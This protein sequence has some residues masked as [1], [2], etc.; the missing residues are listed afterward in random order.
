MNRIWSADAVGGD[1]KSGYR[2]SREQKLAKSFQLRL[3]KAS[4]LEDAVV[5]PPRSA[6]AVL[7]GQGSLTSLSSRAISPSRNVAVSPGST[8]AYAASRDEELRGSLPLMEMER[9]FLSKL[10]ELEQQMHEKLAKVIEMAG[11]IS[12]SCEE[13]FSQIE[14]KALECQAAVAKIQSETIHML[15]FVDRE[16]IEFMRKQL[17]QVQV[18]VTQTQQ[19][20]SCKEGQ[21][22]LAA[23]EASQ[24]RSQREV[25]RLIAATTSLKQSFEQAMVMASERQV[26]FDTVQTSYQRLDSTLRVELSE[27]RQELAKR[28][29][30]KSSTDLDELRRVVRDLAS[31]CRVQGEKQ[32]ELERDLSE[33]RETAKIARTPADADALHSRLQV[34]EERRELS[35]NISPSL[36][37]R[38]LNILPPRN[39]PCHQRSVDRLDR[40]SP[41]RP[42]G[43]ASSDF[44]SMNY[45]YP[46]GVDPK[47]YIDP[48]RLRH[49]SKERGAL[50]P[51]SPRSPTTVPNS[52]HSLGPLG[53][54]STWSEA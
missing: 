43:P 32:Q 19:E 2:P 33:V 30:P 46:E 40:P 42:R 29:T 53:S 44:R 22:S 50:T 3:P 13:R 4:R 45:D 36:T 21:T 23:V 24:A 27:L 26:E 34:Q 48:S 17:Q 51:G 14:S 52:C 1:V 10:Q 54:C 35:S 16:D 18:A 39:D 15:D 12:T 31:L 38:S 7:Q 9:S 41:S 28:D 20:L 25:E 49:S 8:L 37:P 47:P 11:I 5:S 6:R